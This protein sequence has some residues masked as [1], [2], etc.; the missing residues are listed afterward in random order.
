[1]RHNV[2]L[3]FLG[4]VGVVSAHFQLAFPPPRGAFNEDEEPNFC[5]A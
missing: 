4:L 3:I 5:G 2:A 1:M